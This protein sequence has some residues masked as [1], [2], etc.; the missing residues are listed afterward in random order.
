MTLVEA[1]ELTS[2]AQD[3]EK[4]NIRGLFSPAVNTVRV[5]NSFQILGEVAEQVDGNEWP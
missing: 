2:A 5:H 1:N 4:F 3:F